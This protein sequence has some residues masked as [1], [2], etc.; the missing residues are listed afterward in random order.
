MERSSS[1]QVGENIILYPYGFLHYLC[2]DK[3]FFL[4]AAF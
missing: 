4:R 3:L 1:A 2:Q